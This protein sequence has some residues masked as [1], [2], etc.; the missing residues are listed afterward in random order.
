MTLG[1][2]WHSRTNNIKLK[3]DIHF[4]ITIISMT[5]KYANMEMFKPVKTFKV[6]V[7]HNSQKNVE[8]KNT[9]SCTIPTISG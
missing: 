8:N 5:T 9:A 4:L 2:I 7:F 6:N 3:Y 1:Q